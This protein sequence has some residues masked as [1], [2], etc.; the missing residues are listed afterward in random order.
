MNASKARSKAIADL[1]SKG[2]VRKGKVYCS[3]WCGAGCTRAAFEAAT[4]SAKTLA[5]ALGSAWTYRVWENF[6]WHW[7]IRSKC[8]RWTIT[9]PHARGD[10]FSVWLQS[11]GGGQ[12][13]AHGKTPRAA[14]LTALA[15]ACGK[16]AAVQALVVDVPE[17]G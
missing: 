3:P 5:A 10:K 4:L 12:Y 8:G 16:L 15:M 14:M 2:P 11:D 6:G 13:I 1:Y 9:P 17:V 7:E